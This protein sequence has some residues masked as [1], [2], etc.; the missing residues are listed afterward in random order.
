MREPSLLEEG[1]EQEESLG[2]GVRGKRSEVRGTVRDGGR[3]GGC[4]KG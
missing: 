3:G 2:G 4:K 1:K